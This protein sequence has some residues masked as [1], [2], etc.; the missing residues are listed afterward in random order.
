MVSSQGCPSCSQNP[1]HFFASNPFLSPVPPLPM[2]STSFPWSSTH[3]GSSSHNPFFS[4]PDSTHPVSSSG[5][6]GPASGS[7][8]PYTG[9][10]DLVTRKLEQ[11]DS[12]LAAPVVYN[13]QGNNPAWKPFEAQSLKEL[14]KAQKEFGRESSYFKTLLRATFSTTVMILRDIKNLFSCLF[15]PSEFQMW[16]ADWRKQL[17]EL[18]PILLQDQASAGLTMDRLTGDE[19]LS[20][21]QE[22]ARNILE[23][24][25]SAI[26]DAAERAFVLM[27]PKLTPQLNNTQIEQGSN[28]PFI[29]FIDKLRVAV[30]KQI[31]DFKTREHIITSIAK[32][33]ANETCKKVILNLPFEPPPTLTQ[34][35]QACTR[36]VQINNLVSKKQGGALSGTRQEMVAVGDVS[37]LLCYHRGGKGHT[38]RFC[39]APAH[40]VKNPTKFAPKFVSLDQQQGN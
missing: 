30:E 15:S 13:H 29:D 1:F 6:H 27:P 21:P 11:I 18:L 4:C 2:T 39:R 33:N 31:E 36:L 5:S 37:P 10:E 25:L 32:A 16:T 38:S 20:K 19:L 17:S 23:T 28:E 3:Y 40:M 35:I 26:R 8:A 22:Q 9:C 24:V 34:M 14:Y 12:P 7:H